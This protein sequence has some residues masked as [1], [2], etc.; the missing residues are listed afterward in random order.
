MKKLVALV[1]DVEF[2]GR[3][4]G[5]LIQQNELAGK[6][7]DRIIRTFVQYLAVEGHDFR[8]FDNVEAQIVL[9]SPVLRL[10]IDVEQAGPPD[11]LRGGFRVDFLDQLIF[12]QGLY[13]RR[14][15]RRIVAGGVL[16]EGIVSHRIEGL[17]VAEVQ[18]AVS[19]NERVQVDIEFAVRG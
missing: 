12:L 9:R 1:G 6:I 14:Q 8:A 10:D 5:S 11:D 2:G 13:R 4:G 7:I 19:G 15:G 3:V 17:Q 16:I 18:F